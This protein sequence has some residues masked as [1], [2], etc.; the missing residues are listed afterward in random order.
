MTCGF[1]RRVSFLVLTIAAYPFQPAFSLEHSLAADPRH[2]DDAASWSASSAGGGLGKSEHRGVGDLRVGRDR[3]PIPPERGADPADAGPRAG[4]TVARYGTVEV[5]LVSARE[6]NAESGSVNPFDDVSFALLVTSPT[7]RTYRVDGFFDGD[8]VGG[9]RGGVFKARVFADEL[10]SWTW[11]S[12]SSETSLHDAR[13]GFTCAGTLSGDF[14]RGPIIVRP[15]RPWTFFFKETKPVY[16]LGKFLDYDA[17]GKLQY[18]HTMFGESWTESDRRKLLDRHLGMELNKINVYLANKGDYGG[19][20]TT[21]WVGTAA[22]NDKQRFD[23]SRWR[24]WDRWVRT[25]RDEG[26]VAHLWFFADDSGFGSLPDADRERLIRYA[27]ARMSAYANTMFVLVLEWQEGWSEA[28]VHH[29]ANFLD[30]HNPWKRLLSV[31]GRT[32]DFAFPDAPWADYMDLQ[33]GI[34]RDYDDIHDLGV[35]TRALAAKPVLNEEFH[36]GDEN[37]EGRQKA[38]AAF[39]AGAGGSGTGAGL[40]YLEIGRAHV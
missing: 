25:M 33:S 27:M 2:D 14:S 1:P 24:T 8:G 5:V 38:W 7:G 35:S 32:G 16:L 18:S 40:K 23:L 28:E 21:P 22:D 31:H 20:A 9:P 13:G 11:K 15:Y 30:E 3:Q 39:T 12:E 34:P 26:L 6:F 29:H 10:G 17:D 37:T 36:T 4:P 19:V